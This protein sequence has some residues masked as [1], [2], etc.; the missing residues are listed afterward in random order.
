MNLV[1]WLPA[2]FALGLVSIGC[3]LRHRLRL[4]THLRSRPNDRCHDR[5]DRIRHRLPVHGVYPARVV[6]TA[7]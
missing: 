5:G 7:E 2:M 6:L 1:V 3:L 4:L